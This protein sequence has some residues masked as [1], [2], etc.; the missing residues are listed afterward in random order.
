[1]LNWANLV[2]KG[3]ARDIGIGWNEDEWDAI[4]KLEK[5]RGLSRILAAEYLR[6][7]I[8]TVEDY[9][10]D[11]KKGNKIKVHEELEKE[12]KELG[13]EFAPET[14]ST[15][16]EKEIAR[17]KAEPIIPSV[18]PSTEPETTNGVGIGT[19]PPASTVEGDP[20]TE[21]VDDETLP[22]AN[23]VEGTPE[24]RLLDKDTIKARLDELGIKY[25][26]RKTA[27][28]LTEILNE[29]TSKEQ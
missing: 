18:A 15:V 3:R 22:T 4:L 26:G 9:D 19:P 16:L 20:K 12:A 29:H 25:D 7:G 11:I 10:K 17:K 27:E 21:K 28:G 8:M 24:T 2:V 5:E 23:P 1:M 14:P 6:K 13:I